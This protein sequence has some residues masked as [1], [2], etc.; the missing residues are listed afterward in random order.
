MVDVFAV[1][2]DAQVGAAGDEMR[3]Q[4]QR[5][6][7]ADGGHQVEVAAEADD[8]PG[9]G[10]LL[11]DA[12]EFRIQAEHGHGGAA[13]HATSVQDADGGEAELGVVFKADRQ[14][15]A[16]RAAADDQS[17]LTHEVMRPNHV[18][19]GAGDHATADQ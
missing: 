15:A 2:G 19:G 1:G 4:A 6:A 13:R 11:G 5:L 14:L 9:D 10:E 18:D 17:A 16:E 3:P 8:H 12:L 7:G